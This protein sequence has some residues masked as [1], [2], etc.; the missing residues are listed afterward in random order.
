[1]AQ[2]FIEG[3]IE[4]ILAAVVVVV[5]L[6]MVMCFI[7]FTIGAWAIGVAEILRWVMQ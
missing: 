2:K 3:A 5:W 4:G 1:M 6:F 7:T